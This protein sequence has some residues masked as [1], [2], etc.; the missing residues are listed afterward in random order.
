MRKQEKPRTLLKKDVCSECGTI[1][2][3]FTPK[4]NF[5]VSTE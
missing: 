1:K 4:K 5:D 2:H 3:A